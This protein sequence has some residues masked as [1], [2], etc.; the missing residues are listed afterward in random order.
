MSS[1]DNHWRAHMT[2]MARNIWTCA[3]FATSSFNFGLPTYFISHYCYERA[4][5]VVF[6]EKKF[7]N[8]VEQD[9]WLW[10]G[11]LQCQRS[12]TLVCIVL[13]PCFCFA[14]SVCFGSFKNL[15]L[16]G[17]VRDWRHFASRR[18]PYTSICL[19]NFFVRSM[20]AFIPLFVDFVVIWHSGTTRFKYRSSRKKSVDYF[21]C[22]ICCYGLDQAL[23]HQ[24]KV[25]G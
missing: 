13:T 6:C 18:L 12:H 17:F 5:Y 19:S 22:C 10:C 23:F 3:V 7:L 16:S 14:S 9:C 1:D 15:I 8:K 21:V 20:F 4:L 2:P 11:K 24:L 25:F